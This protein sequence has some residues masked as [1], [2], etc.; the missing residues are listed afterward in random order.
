MLAGIL[1]VL[2]RTFYRPHP[3]MRPY[4]AGS[5]KKLTST[6]LSFSLLTVMAG[7]AVAPAL[8]IIGEHFSDASP[9]AVKFVVGLPPLFIVLVNLFFDRICRLAGT[10]TIALTGVLLY[11][12]SG[13]GAF[14]VDSLPGRARS[15]SI[16]F[17]FCLSFGRCWVLRSVS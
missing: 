16:R 3:R 5:V 13:A 1:P 17:R 15:S 11:V 4:L 12:A 9:L 8:G 2:G 10:R 6:I 14:F 7:A